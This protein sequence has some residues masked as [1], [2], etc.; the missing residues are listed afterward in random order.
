MEQLNNIVQILAVI[1]MTSY[2]LSLL[3]RHYWAFD[4]FSHFKIQYFAGGLILLLPLLFFKSYALTLAMLIIAG[5]SYADIRRP[6]STIQEITNTSTP[7]ITLMQYNKF[8]GNQRYTKIIGYLNKNTYHIDIIIFQEVLD[9]DILPLTE[10]TKKTYPYTLPLDGMRPNEVLILSKYPIENLEIKKVCPNLCDTYGIRFKIT[11]SQTSPPIAIYTIHTEVPES[12]RKQVLRNIE[13]THMAQWITKDET[14]N[15]VFMGDWNTTPYAPIFS[16]ILKISGLNYYNQGILPETTWPSFF[17]LP[18]LKIPI[19]HILFS[20][21][22][23]LKKI[24][25][26]PALGSD[27]H[28]LSATFALE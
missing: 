25:K 24:K 23:K 12:K 3:A 8:F 17:G 6:M 19:D 16:D 5:A 13:L 27:H 28:S 4:L 22:M 9:C 10:A 11:H 18:F 7:T 1:L 20:P 21:S 15:I 14:Q 26:G 2:T